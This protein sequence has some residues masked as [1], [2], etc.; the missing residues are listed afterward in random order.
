MKNSLRC[1]RM[2]IVTILVAGATPALA[3]D[4]VVQMKDKGAEGAMVFEPSFV[5][6]AVGDRIRFVPTNTNHNA[7]TIP[8]MLPDGVAPSKGQLGKEF[9]LTI[10]K[11]GVYGVKCLPHYSLGMV[12]LVQVGPA[13]ANL[14][15]AKAVNLPPF[16]KKRMAALF[17]KVK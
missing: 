10:T 9:D 13:P 12:A 6:A 1:C 2:A 4:I 11:P 16:A 14:A 8:T 15:K 7:E 3:K 5:K 17:A